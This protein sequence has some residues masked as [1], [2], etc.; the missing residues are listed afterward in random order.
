[1]RRCSIAYHEAGH[2][3]VAHRLGVE[4]E[5]VTI[6]P[7]HTCHGHCAHADLFCA[8]GHGSDRANLERAIQICLAGPLAQAWLLRRYFDR[9]RGGRQDYDCASGLARYLAGSAGEREFLRY[10]ERRT[11]ALVDHLWSDI[12]RVAQALLERDHLSG[13]EVKDIIEAP[14]RLEQ[15]DRADKQRWIEAMADPKDPVII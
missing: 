6:V 13:T 12:E 7:D 4:V 8:R 2:A 14:R 15:E 9:R 1:M 11:Q 5:H 3:V 10:Q